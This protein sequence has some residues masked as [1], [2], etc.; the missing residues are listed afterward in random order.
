MLSPD[1]VNHPGSIV[2]FRELSKAV[3]NARANRLRLANPDE[4]R[5]LGSLRVICPSGIDPLIARAECSVRPGRLA[6]EIETRGGGRDGKKIDAIRVS[7]KLPP[8]KHRVCDWLFPL[9][10]IPVTEAIPGTLRTGE[11]RLS[12]V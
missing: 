2:L 4:N 11:K 10:R 8:L 3:T 5:Q 6:P 7:A 12:M 9:A 1:S